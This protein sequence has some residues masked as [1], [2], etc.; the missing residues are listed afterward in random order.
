MDPK[1]QAKL[2]AARNAVQEADAKVKALQ[3]EGQKS[4]N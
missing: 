1:K 4:V 3:P 2:E